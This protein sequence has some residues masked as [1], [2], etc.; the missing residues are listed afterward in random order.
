MNSSAHSKTTLYSLLSLAWPIIVSRSTQVVVG[1]SDALMVAHLGESVLASVTAGAMNSFAAFIFPMGIVFI[2]SSF[3][4]QLA[5]KGEA[6]SARRYGWYG[7]GV[8]T[9]AQ[10]LALVMIP[11]LPTLLGLFK[12]EP[13]VMSGLQ[14]YLAIRLLST[15]TGVGI[16]ALGNYYGGLG[17]TSILMK[18]N[19]T[20][21]SLNVGLNWCLIDGHLGFPAWGLEGA[22]WASV[23]ST[24]LAF[25]GFFLVF[26]LQGRGL[27]AAKL[28]LAEF[29]RMLRF[30]VPSGFNW[31]F[32]FFAFITFINIVV[33]GLGTR[34]PRTCARP[35]V[36]ATGP[37]IAA[38]AWASAS[39]GQ[40]VDASFTALR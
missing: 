33:A 3:S 22:A 26:I 39:L 17:N 16:E 37:A 8:A 34:M 23:I 2:V 10:L 18:A 7:L 25:G 11:A 14:A 12:Y 31:A 9:F 1:L 27:A 15:G 40:S 4:S 21:M 6:A 32:E 19:L 28:N 35:T 38:P 36:T 24:S 5:G 29:L 13:E 30:G 20:A